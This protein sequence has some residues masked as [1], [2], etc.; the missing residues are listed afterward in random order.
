[1]FILVLCWKEHNESYCGRIM[2]ASAM[3]VRDGVVSTDLMLS[4][5]TVRQRSTHS[6]LRAWSKR[7]ILKEDLTLSFC[8]HRCQHRTPRVLPY[9]CWLLRKREVMLMLSRKPKSVTLWMHEWKQIAVLL[10]ILVLINILHNTA[11]KISHS[12][13]SSTL[14]HDATSI[15]NV[16]H[17]ILHELATFGPKESIPRSIVQN[18]ENG[19]A[20]WTCRCDELGDR[21]GMWPQ[22]TQQNIICD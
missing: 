6:H 15:W 11:R 17:V 16:M 10:A 21:Y 9:D 13:P 1:M 3:W 7:S 8:S 12:L 14:G 5:S 19:G 20:D 22:W 2:E 18:R 4:L